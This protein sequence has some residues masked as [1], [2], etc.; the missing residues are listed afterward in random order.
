MILCLIRTTLI[1]NNVDGVN[2]C[3]ENSSSKWRI[4][5]LVSRPFQ[6]ELWLFRCQRLSDNIKTATITVN[7]YITELCSLTFNGAQKRSFEFLPPNVFRK[8]YL[9][10]FLCEF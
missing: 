3:G 5:C 2:G 10:V 8:I 1:C 4:L 7:V 6:W 9:M